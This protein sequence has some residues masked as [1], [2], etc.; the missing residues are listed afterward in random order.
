MP[1]FHFAPSVGWMN[2]PNGLI[3]WNGRHHLFF[4]YN[5]NS[6]EHH[7]VG[8]GHASSTD[9]VTWQ[10]HPDALLPGSGDSRYDRDGCWSGCA[11]VDQGVVTFVYTGLD[12]SDQLPCI[13]RATDPS[14]TE[15]VKDIRNP[16]VAEPPLADVTAFRDHSV[17]PTPNGWQH[18]VGG[19][20]RD[21]GGALFEYRGRDLA[22]WTF[23]RVL[24]DAGRSEIPGAVWECPDLFAIDGVDVLIVSI[25]DDD[26]PSRPTARVWCTT[27]AVAEGG[28][29]SMRAAVLDHGDRFYAPQSYWTDDK[30]R[31]MFGWVRTELDPAVDGRPSRGAM[32]LPR[33]LI[34]RGDR[35]LQSP[36]REL[37]QLRTSPLQ[38]SLDPYEPVSSLELARPEA[39]LELVIDAS[40]D[41]ITLT[42]DDTGARFDIAV[43]DLRVPDNARAEHEAVTV[44]FDDGII[45][46]FR[47]GNA[48]TWTAMSLRVVTSIQLTHGEHADR[49]AITAWPLQAPAAALT[50]NDDDT[51]TV[52]HAHADC[53]AGCRH[54][55]N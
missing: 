8:W 13:A 27:G 12:G 24:L 1:L 33:E 44:F 49:A 7:R 18:I 5:R 14:L 3:Q 32:S 34:V 41:T 16:V 42:D 26:E 38:A 40:V 22:D 54:H 43:S 50:S 47:G 48:A 6:L 45:E 55:Q 28:F 51:A 17:I 10:Q 19:G 35:L 31:I 11:V 4:Q 37:R 9:L 20:T 29:S 23:D 2:D 53:A 52:D 15:F 39:A 21:L 46:A 25:I 36:A 30:R